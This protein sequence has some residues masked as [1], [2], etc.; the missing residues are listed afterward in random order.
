MGDAEDYSAVSV[1]LE[2]RDAGLYKSEVECSPGGYYFVAVYDAGEYALRVKGPDGWA[3]APSTRAVSV[4]E[5]GASTCTDDMH[6]ALRGFR[7]SGSVGVPAGADASGLSVTLKGASG[8]ATASVD[9]RGHFAFDGVAPGDYDVTAAHDTWTISGGPVRA[10][11]GWGNAEVPAGLEVAGFD[12]SGAVQGGDGEPLRNVPVLLFGATAALGGC[13]APS[14]TEAAAVDAAAVSGAGDALCVARTDAAGSFSFQGVRPG[15]YRVAPAFVSAG[16]AAFEVSPAAQRVAVE[17]SSAAVAQPFQLVGFSLGGRVVGVAGTPGEGA[18]VAGASVFVDGTKRATTDKDGRY[19]LSKL[20]TGTVQLRASKVGQYFEQLASVALSPESGALPDLH[21]VRFDVC[22]QVAVR[23]VPESKRP[24]GAA[25]LPRRVAA[26]DADAGTPAGEATT[27]AT[28]GYCIAGGLAPGAYDLTAPVSTAERRAGLILTPSPLRVVVPHDGGVDDATFVPSAFSVSG[29]VACLAPACGAGVD[30]VLQ[31]HKG[32]PV[33]ARVGDD[34]SFRFDGVWPGAYALSAGHARGAFC[35]SEGDGE[36]AA[37]GAQRSPAVRVTVDDADVGDVVISQTGFVFAAEAS[38][39]MSVRVGDS[40]LQLSRGLNRVCIATPGAHAVTPDACFRY[41]ADSFDD[42][43][44]ASAGDA[45]VAFTVERYR[46]RGEVQLRGNASPRPA[47]AL[48]LRGVAT[49]ADGSAGKPVKLKVTQDEADPSVYRYTTFAAAGSTVQLT[50]RNSKGA[51]ND[52]AALLLFE[53]EELTVAVRASGCPAPLPAIE[54]RE[55]KYIEGV[56]EPALGGVEVTAARDGAGDDDDAVVAR[57]TSDDAGAYRV[58]PLR[59]GVSYSLSAAKDGYH[60]QE[61]E[62]SGG[63][64][65]ARR[66]LGAVSASVA[67]G[68][69]APVGGVLL[70]LSGA[71]AGAKRYSHNAATGDDGTY[72]FPGLFPGRYFVRPLL[73]EYKF[74]PSS[75]EV[76]VAE[77]ATAATAFKATRVAFSAF[78]TVRSLNGAPEPGLTVTAQAEGTAPE[79]ATTDAEGR[80]RVRGLQP[81]VEYTVTVA[82][83]EAGAAAAAL[84]RT[85][86]ASRS[87][88]TSAAAGDEHGVDFVGFRRRRQT[89]AL[90]GTVAVQGDAALAQGLQVRVT[91]PGDAEHPVQTADVGFSRHFEFPELTAGEYDVALWSPL[92]EEGSGWA[93]QP[94]TTRVRLGGLARVHVPLTFAAA[95]RVDEGGDAVASVNVLIVLLA[96][97]AYAAHALG[98]VDLHKLRGGNDAP[99]EDWASQHVPLHLRESKKSKAK[100]RRKH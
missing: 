66:R 8:E 75:A 74:E 4:R 59:D 81:G 40:A 63:T 56:I 99:V 11:V 47:S 78:G 22:G 20:T 71:R 62:G 67:S 35:W 21:T 43:D 25:L 92:G 85:E 7:L 51:D 58:G 96:A 98:V 18:G 14:S 90:T 77:G 28:G 34:G 31:S 89:F 41:S 36:A 45:P 24:P 64:R 68:D 72:H 52:G 46:L 70:S 6:F 93:V 3:F 94:S 97:A 82:E 9:A 12:V 26:A 48:N 53:P 73:K 91:L 95:E 83:A 84:E 61:V 5:D 16:G 29:R 44:T 15:E 55:G 54:A 39:A 69:G 10:T 32:E 86:P 50:P 30:V 23:D 27:D 79:T 17:A 49:A 1:V 100:G 80:F 60:F 42:F 88:V 87:V 38:E 65:F 33:T 2:T 76:D 13:D 37:G 57:A 19:T